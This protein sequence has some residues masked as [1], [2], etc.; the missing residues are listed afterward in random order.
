MEY[1]EKL[2]T[3]FGKTLRSC[4][5]KAGLTQE[6]LAKLA[7]TSASFIGYL[8]AGKRMP[9]LA[10]FITLTTVLKIDPHEMLDETI[11]LMNMLRVHDD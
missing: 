11:R 3:A 8:E 2:D 5:E 7:E 10:T 9:T 6:A 4:R 1:P